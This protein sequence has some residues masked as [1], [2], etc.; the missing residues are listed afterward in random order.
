V[1]FI[2]NA[3]YVVFFGVVAFFAAKLVFRRRLANGVRV[4]LFS[5]G[6][7]FVVALIAAGSHIPAQESARVAGS[8]ATI[9]DTSPDTSRSCDTMKTL[10]AEPAVGSLESVTS[11]NGADVA[12]GSVVA[13]TTILRVTGW[14]FDKRS[15]DAARGICILVDGRPSKRATVR[16]G[17]A[18]RDVA[19]A[20]HTEEALA[21]GY[22]ATLPVA[23]IAP[24]THR[25]GVAVGSNDGTFRELT[26]S[27]SIVVP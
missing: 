26:A 18:R 12:S 1:S 21:S 5:F 7:A 9:L 3:P 16:F 13:R 27:R 6:V 19:T 20:M 2:E 4:E 8:S 24:G 25:I 23:S 11:V 15:P 17:F 10:L 22:V 14:G